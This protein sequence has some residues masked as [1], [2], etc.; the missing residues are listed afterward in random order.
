MTDGVG[1]DPATV[2]ARRWKQTGAS[3]SSAGQVV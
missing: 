3:S 1:L 2:T